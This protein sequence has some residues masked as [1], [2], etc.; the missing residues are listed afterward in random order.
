MIFGFGTGSSSKTRVMLSDVYMSNEPTLAT[1]SGAAQFIL[2][3][4][5]L[6]DHIQACPRGGTLIE[7]IGSRFE[8]HMGKARRR[9]VFTHTA[10]KCPCHRAAV[11]A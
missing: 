9:S 5:A 11:H 6:S 7:W 4:A 2:A 3:H 1:L 10:A 8:K